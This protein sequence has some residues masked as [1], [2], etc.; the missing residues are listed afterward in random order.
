MRRYFTCLL[1]TK[2]LVEPRLH[3]FVSVHNRSLC[4]LILRW[5]EDFNDNAPYYLLRLASRAGF[6]I[7]F[8]LRH[9]LNVK[10]YRRISTSPDLCFALAEVD[11]PNEVGQ[12]ALATSLTE[13]RPRDGNCSSLMASR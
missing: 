4:S 8:V 9:G 7:R 12:G 11:H 10:A 5:I 6:A 1:P 3:H 13:V 2:L